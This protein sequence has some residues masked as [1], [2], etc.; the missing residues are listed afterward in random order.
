MLKRQ[1]LLIVIAIA[2]TITARF[3]SLSIVGLTDP[4]EGRFASV[5]LHMLQTGDWLIPKINYGDGWQDYLAKPPLHIWLTALC[6]KYFGASDFSARVPG[7]IFY[8]LNGLIAFLLGRRV[9]LTTGLLAAL[10]FLASVGGFFIGCASTT[11]PL[12]TLLYAGAVYCLSETIIYARP[13]PLLG[14][15]GFATIGLGILTKGPL[16]LALLFLNYAVYLFI[17]KDYSSLKRIPWFSG[18]VVTLAIACPWYILVNEASPGFIRYYLI[19]ENINR[20]LYANASI[21]YGSL[22]QYPFGTIWIFVALASLPWILTQF[23]AFKAA[24]TKPNVSNKASNI[25]FTSALSPLL[26]FTFARNI[27]PTYSLPAMPGLSVLI[28]KQLHEKCTKRIMPVSLIFIL[29]Y[30]AAG[31]YISS[32]PEITFSSK[33]MLYDIKQNL[34]DIAQDKV[35]VHGPPANSMRFYTESG[36]IKLLEIPE[37]LNSAPNSKYVLVSKKYSSDLAG[38]YK[39]IK[40]YGKWLLMELGS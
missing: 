15:I 37:D 35:T 18:A 19:E 21:K 12:I 4:S 24:I 38:R 23:S 9:S 31:N 20:F 14:I 28:A 3:F 6:F 39:E 22:K 17:T 5:A 40:S 16:I 7:F 13:R 29:I 30:L 34:G 11:D 25:C 1:D 36:Q 10:I 27:L 2:A 8:C 26:F 32:R 33:S